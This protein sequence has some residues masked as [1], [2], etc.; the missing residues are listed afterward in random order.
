MTHASISPAHDADA[1]RG[2]RHARAQHLIAAD[3]HALLELEVLLATLPMCATGRVF[4]EIPD[5]GWVRP[6]AAPSRM[7]V[8]WLARSAR[9]GAP[10]SARM[11][12]AGEALTRAVTAY[13]DE[14]LCENESACGTSISLLGG[15][16]S[17]A[18][19]VEHLTRRRG[20]R[21]DAI[22]VP[23]AFAAYV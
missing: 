19:I 15:F 11:C 22:T 3:E 23:D 16:S 12:A 8:T 7:T 21:R 10:G 20:L 1:C 2:R 18:D 9:S 17:S 5:A 14:A 13:A 4:I 6:L